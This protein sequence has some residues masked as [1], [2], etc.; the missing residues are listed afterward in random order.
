MDIDNY[1]VPND[2][3]VAT[4]R[5]I[6]KKRSINKLENYRSVFLLNTFSKIY[7][8]YLLNSITPFANNALSIFISAYR[9]MSNN[10][11]IRLIENWKQSLDNQNS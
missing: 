10:A 8:R 1:N 11:L 3:N 2:T 5:T 7:E 6:Y 4:V 9:K